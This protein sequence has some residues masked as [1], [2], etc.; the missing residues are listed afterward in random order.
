[1]I[2]TPEMVRRAQLEQGRQRIGARGQYDG[3]LRDDDTLI[4]H[5]DRA[6]QLAAVLRAAF[7][8]EGHE[9]G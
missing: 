1:M 5:A 9:N 7:D 6:D 3:E 4:F 2:V 8:D